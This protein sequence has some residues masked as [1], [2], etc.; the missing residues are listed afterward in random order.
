MSLRLR[1]LDSPLT[2]PFK[3]DCVLVVL[4]MHWVAHFV[5]PLS[6]VGLALSWL[7]SSLVTVG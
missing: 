4:N 7:Y 5:A 2:L 1:Q 6:V 3:F